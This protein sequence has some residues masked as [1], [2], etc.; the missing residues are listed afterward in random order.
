LESQLAERV[1][2]YFSLPRA[3]RSRAWRFAFLIAGSICTHYRHSRDLYEII[4]TAL[5]HSDTAGRS[6]DSFFIWLRAQRRARS[7]W[8]GSSCAAQREFLLMKCE[9]NLRRSHLLLNEHATLKVLI[10][11]PDRRAPAENKRHIFLLSPFKNDR[12]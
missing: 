6:L 3:P 2:A 9:L 10:F 1:I 8:K 12:V 11:H 4:Y 7:L 5:T